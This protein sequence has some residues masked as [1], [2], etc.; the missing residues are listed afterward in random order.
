[1]HLNFPYEI[2]MVAANNIGSEHTP[3]HGDIYDTIW[4]L[5]RDH[6]D[7]QIIFGF[8]I[9]NTRTN[10]IP[11]GFDDWYNTP[12]DAYTAYNRSELNNQT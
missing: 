8:C 2:R 7:C 11:D 12:E 5:K 10:L 9:V 3:L 4:K 1:M 6:P